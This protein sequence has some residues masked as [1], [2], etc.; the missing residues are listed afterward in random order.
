MNRV[1][2]VDDNDIN[3]TLLKALVNKLGDCEPVMFQDLPTGLAWC[4]E[5]LPDLLIVDYMMP[6]LDALQLVARFR[7]APACAE[8][9]V[10]MITANDDKDVRNMLAL[11]SSPK[12]LA[13][14]AARA[15][16]RQHGG[17]REKGGAGPLGFLFFCSFLCAK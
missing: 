8:I 9:P 7:A 15:P 13:D 5:N 14:R 12:K 3:L 6:E 2:I 17:R 11:G 4:I 1:A 10:L 16:R